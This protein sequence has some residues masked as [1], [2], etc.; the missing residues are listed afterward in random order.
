MKNRNIFFLKRYLNPNAAMVNRRQEK[1]SVQQ[2]IS[3]VNGQRR[4]TQQTIDFTHFLIT[5]TR[6]DKNA[7]FVVALWTVVFHLLVKTNS[8]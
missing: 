4:T 8:N 5:Q 2:R 6:Q 3:I 7:G 1:C